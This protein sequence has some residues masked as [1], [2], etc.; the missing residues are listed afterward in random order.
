MVRF[1]GTEATG[2]VP[3]ILRSCAGATPEP[4]ENTP[5]VSTF[6]QSMSFCE[7]ISMADLPVV[8]DEHE[9]K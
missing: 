3:I 1:L 6:D 9:I 8:P 7:A 4:Q 2:A 5:T